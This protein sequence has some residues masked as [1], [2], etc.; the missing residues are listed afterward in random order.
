MEYLFFIEGNIGFSLKVK[1]MTYHWTFYIAFNV[2]MADLLP[3]N[4]AWSDSMWW[5][6]QGWN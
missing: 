4:P 1:Q 6:L 3:S 5:L 2:E